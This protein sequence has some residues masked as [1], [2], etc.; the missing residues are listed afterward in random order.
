MQATQEG[1]K[2]FL[3]HQ[4][5]MANLKSSAF[6]TEYAVR[7]FCGRPPQQT[8]RITLAYPF[9]FHHSWL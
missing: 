9:S 5:Q 1:P 2:Q 4:P 7:D 3:K 8:H 6:P